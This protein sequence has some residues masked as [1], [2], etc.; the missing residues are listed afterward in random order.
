MRESERAYSLLAGLGVALFIVISSLSLSLSLT[1]T[2]TSFFLLQERTWQRAEHV[3]QPPTSAAIPH[4]SSHPM[5]SRLS[6][7]EV[8]KSLIAQRSIT[9][10][11]DH[12]TPKEK[13]SER[14]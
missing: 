6:L 8:Q 2:H 5:N 7:I 10:T 14:S 4:S 11:S 13:I 1:H 3:Q 9:N 12:H